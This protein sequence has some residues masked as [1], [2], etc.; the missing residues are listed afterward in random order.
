[1]KLTFTSGGAVIAV[2]LDYDGFNFLIADAP[3]VFCCASDG[4]GECG[5]RGGFQLGHS[6]LSGYKGVAGLA[7]RGSCE[8]R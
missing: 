5:Q 8:G 7:K 2:A 6:A 4:T 1:M 3:P